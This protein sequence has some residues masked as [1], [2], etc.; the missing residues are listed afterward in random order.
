M[1]QGTTGLFPMFPD[2]VSQSY[3]PEDPHC[4][5][6]AIPAGDLMSFFA[7]SSRRRSLRLP[8]VIW[9]CLWAMLMFLW[10][11]LLTCPLLCWRCKMSPQPPP[12]CSN[13]H[14]LG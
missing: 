9:G 11:G 6:W 7:V 3:T 14:G 8:W 10:R 2:D 12:G 13:D 5:D 1:L 4:P